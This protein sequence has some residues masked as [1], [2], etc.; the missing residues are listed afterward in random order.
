M[1][2]KDSSALR[3]TERSHVVIDRGTGTAAEGQLRTE[4]GFL[5]PSGVVV[6]ALLGDLLP[7]GDLKRMLESLA[8][9]GWGYGRNY[10]YG[11]IELESVEP[12]DKPRDS[13]AFVTLGHCHPTDDLPEAG[14][15]R[16]R[17]VPVR[18]HDPATRRAP[19]LQFATMLDAGACF[20]GSLDGDKPYVGQ[21]LF[22]P[23]QDGDS[24][25]H[26]G[27]APVWPYSRGGAP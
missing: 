3:H 2:E 24:H 26:H 13:G 11:S 16:F 19:H 20:E 8:K 9:E 27:F 15:W 21:M 6:V 7:L 10:G 5:P 17:G 1:V 4:L 22:D 12:L 18:K 25:A 14:W 23:L